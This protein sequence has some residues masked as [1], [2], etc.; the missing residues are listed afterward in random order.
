MKNTQKRL[1]L[2]F[3]CEIYWKYALFEFVCVYFDNV[4]AKYGCC[5][6]NLKILGF[7][8]DFWS[9]RT[10]LCVFCFILVGLNFFCVLLSY[11]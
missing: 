3:F 1:V 2:V 7:K 8:T 10:T 11:L 9:V 5:S 4:I 6:R